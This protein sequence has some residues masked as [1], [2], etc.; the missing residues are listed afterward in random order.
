MMLVVPDSYRKE[1][2]IPRDICYLNAA[3]MTPQPRRVLQAA[4]EGAERRAKAWQITPA[5][6]FREVELLRSAFAKQVNC[7]PNNVAIVPSAGYG[8]AVAANNLTID[9]GEIILVLGDQFPSNY[10]SWQRLAQQTGATLHVVSKQA[11]QTWASA[12]LET[13]RQH[14][15]RIKIAALARHHWSTGESI[16]LDAVCPILRDQGCKIVL[17]L[18][19]SIGAFPIDIETLAPDFMVAAGYKWLFCPY[20]TSFLY[21]ADQHFEGIPIE[22]AWMSRDGAEDFSQLANYTDQYQPGARRFDA[23]ERSSFSNI[24]GAIAALGMI[25]EWG[26]ENIS[27]DLG[28]TSLKIAS[29]LE[30]HGFETDGASTRAPHFQSA[31]LTTLDTRELTSRLVVDNVFVSQRGDRLRLAPHLY[32][33]Q[34]DL[35]RFDDSLRKAML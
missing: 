26:V 17:D 22:E 23:G 19:Q 21:V 25:D 6:F 8:V 27:R 32:T 5:D 18:T 24:A 33:D 35:E 14:G 20:G 12:I 1:F 29:I 7:S 10:Y 34:E 28:N 15:D 9:A 3:Y 13:V 16:D 11:D 30:K 31:R 4:T 2:D